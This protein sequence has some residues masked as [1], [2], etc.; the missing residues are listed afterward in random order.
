MRIE[1][2]IVRV[3]IVR[4]Y[5]FTL[6]ELLVV[7]AIIAILAAI[8]LPGLSRAK[9]SARTVACINNIRQ[10]GTATM[11]YTSDLGR[12]PSI[13]EWLYARTNK[14]G[15]SDLTAGQLYPYLKSK[16]IYRCPSEPVASSPTTAV[17]HSY[18]MQ[19]MMCHAHD[20]SVCLAPSRTVYFLE[21]T[22]AGRTFLEGMA[23]IPLPPKLAFRHNRREH[24]LMV[25]THVERFTRLQY[26]SASVDKRF[27]Y[28]TD[29]TDRSGSP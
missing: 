20:G 21:V 1:R 2:S 12:L 26:N 24:F 6:L 10:L 14:I 9:E 25:D 27:W 16:D 29:K 3:G 28:P 7:I 17:D 8:L 22:N 18:Q 4:V 11:V 5:A 19:C 13:L 15:G 23:S